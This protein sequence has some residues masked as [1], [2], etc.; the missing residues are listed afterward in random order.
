MAL[1]NPLAELAARVTPPAPVEVLLVRMVEILL[2]LLAAGVE[3]TVIIYF[4]FMLISSLID[5]NRF[6]V[7]L[8]MLPRFTQEYLHILKRAIT[9]GT[10]SEAITMSP[11]KNKSN[12][13]LSQE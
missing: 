10:L 4:V 5:I 8:E 7:G 6:C 1:I 9:N 13:Q 11:Y 12:I 3:R 2:L